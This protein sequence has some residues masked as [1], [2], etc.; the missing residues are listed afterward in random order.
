MGLPPEGIIRQSRARLEGLRPCSLW[1]RDAEIESMAREDIRERT[2]QTDEMRSQS[3]DDEREPMDGHPNP[4]EV[5]EDIRRRI[6][7]QRDEMRETDCMEVEDEDVCYKSP[8]PMDVHIRLSMEEETDCMAVEDVDVR[9]ESRMRRSELRWLCLRCFAVKD[10]D[11]QDFDD[12]WRTL[13]CEWN[14]R[15]HRGCTEP[16]KQRL[17]EDVSTGAYPMACIPGKHSFYCKKD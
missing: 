5:W 9:H 15:D 13:K 6:F 17:Y 12:Q 1:S 16:W 7:L 10:D 14:A 11:L 3:V 4:W 8:E 2:R